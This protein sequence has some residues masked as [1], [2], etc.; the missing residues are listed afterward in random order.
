MQQNRQYYRVKGA[1]FVVGCWR[2][3]CMGW[4]QESSWVTSHESVLGHMEELWVKGV[5]VAVSLFSIGSKTAFL[6][7][8]LSY[9]GF[10]C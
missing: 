4:A 5:S 7:F 1:F 9:L 10:E 3:N 8:V 2:M 6:E